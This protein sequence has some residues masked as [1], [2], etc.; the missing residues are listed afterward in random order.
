[1]GPILEGADGQVSFLEG[2]TT[3]LSI[4]SLASWPEREGEEVLLC[5]ARQIGGGGVQPPG[6]P[7]RSPA[8]GGVGGAGRLNGQPHRRCRQQDRGSLLVGQASPP[9]PVPRMPGG[10][11]LPDPTGWEARVKRRAATGRRDGADW[12]EVWSGAELGGS[13]QLSALP[14]SARQRGWEKG[15]PSSLLAPSI[16][17]LRCPP[18][19]RSQPQ[20]TASPSLAS[21]ARTT[22]LLCSAAKPGTPAEPRRGA[23]PCPAAGLL[24]GGRWWRRCFQTLRAKSVGEAGQEQSQAKR[25]SSFLDGRGRSLSKSFHRTIP[26]PGPH[27]GPA[28]GGAAVGEMRRAA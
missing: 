28:V 3:F 23:Q 8:A 10:C 1:M 19:R 14:R 5:L 22:P 9:R 15:E 20:R 27:M 13:G 25:G 11:A 26:S 21:R 6:S 16:Q 17:Q 2:E 12:W 24:C 7:E 18:S 4:L